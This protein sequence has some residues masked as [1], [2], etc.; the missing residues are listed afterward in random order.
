MTRL[1]PSKQGCC[2]PVQ[3]PRRWSPWPPW[4]RIYAILRNFLK[5]KTASCTGSGNICLFKTVTVCWDEQNIE[6]LMTNSKLWLNLNYKEDLYFEGNSN[7]EENSKIVTKHKMWQVFFGRTT[8]KLDK[9]NKVLLSLRP[10]QF[11]NKLMN[12]DSRRRRCLPLLKLVN[13]KGWVN[14]VWLN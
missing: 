3:S 2:P 7:C 10:T 4:P 13:Q 9:G 14:L 12:Y 1:L 8:W 6:S 5:E 11:W